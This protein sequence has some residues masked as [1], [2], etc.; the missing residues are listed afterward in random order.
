MQKPFIVEDEAS[1]F[2]FGRPWLV[3]LEDGEPALASFRTDAEAFEFAEAYEKE[4][5]ETA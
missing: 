5:H 3:M 2:W 1:D 4:Q